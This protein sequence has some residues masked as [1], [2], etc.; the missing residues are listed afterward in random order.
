MASSPLDKQIAYRVWPGCECD[1]STVKAVTWMGVSELLKMARDES[2][3]AVR[4]RRCTD[5]ARDESDN[6]QIVV[7]PERTKVVGVAGAQL[8]RS[9]A[10]TGTSRWETSQCPNARVRRS[11]NLYC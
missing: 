2:G 8:S 4:P 10:V 3:R 7:E 6:E 5:G 11:P 1:W 9:F